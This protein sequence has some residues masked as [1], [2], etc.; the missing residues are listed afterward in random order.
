MAATLINHGATQ[1][2]LRRRTIVPPKDPRADWPRK[3]L[4]KSRVWQDWFTGAGDDADSEIIQ[5]SG[6]ILD[7]LDIVAIKVKL[8][9]IYT[10]AATTELKFETSNTPTGPWTELNQAQEFNS[11]ST[12]ILTFSSESADESFPLRR[13]LRWKATGSAA[14][15]SVCFY[16]TYESL[17]NR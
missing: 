2:D 9:L 10:N 3:R 8:E 6:L 12:Y 14:S 11:A 7:L 5:D 1:E 17:T 15:W 13:F 16:L 4:L